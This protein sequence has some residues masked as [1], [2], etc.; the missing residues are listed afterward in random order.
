MPAPEGRVT[1]AGNLSHLPRSWTE[2][3][4]L[5]P[6]FLIST[7]LLLSIAA[8]AY[9]P[10]EPIT[11]VA[12]LAGT[13]NAIQIARADI[14]ALETGNPK[15]PYRATVVMAIDTM[16]YPTAESVSVE[17]GTDGHF[18]PILQQQAQNVVCS[19]GFP[20]LHLTQHGGKLATYVMRVPVGHE[21]LHVSTGSNKTLTFIW[22]NIGVAQRA[23]IGELQVTG[24]GNGEDRL[25]VRERSSPLIM[26]GY[27]VTPATTL[28]QD[29]APHTMHLCS[30]GL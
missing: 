4:T 17:L 22:Y 9:P 11:L 25:S 20:S 6:S 19:E 16:P 12:E 21:W 18:F 30:I 28:S 8:C 29:Y 14:G 27:P 3:V 13:P 15:G 2:G 1:G 7:F 10:P 23:D 5:A 26:N 24:Q